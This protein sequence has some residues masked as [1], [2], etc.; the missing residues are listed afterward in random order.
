[1]EAC[2]AEH[3]HS[4]SRSGVRTAWASPGL[5]RATS[6]TWTRRAFTG[7]RRGNPPGGRGTATSGAQRILP[8]ATIELLAELDHVAERQTAKHRVRQL[9]RTRAVDHQPE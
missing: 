8:V 4:G 7:L 3:S 5:P 9:L 1:M 6:H 2:A